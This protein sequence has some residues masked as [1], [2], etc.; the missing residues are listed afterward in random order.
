MK[1]KNQKVDYIDTVES[2]VDSEMDI[3]E[4]G[5]FKAHFFIFF[6]RSSQNY[7]IT[8]AY[9]SLNAKSML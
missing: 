8:L 6:L 3:K 7:P 1:K 5:Y 9:F 2:V 4:S